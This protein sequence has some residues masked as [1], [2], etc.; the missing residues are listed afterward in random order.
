MEM[1][2]EEKRMRGPRSGRMFYQASSWLP[3]HWLLLVNTL[4]GALVGVAV[5]VPVL[6]AMGATAV[7]RRAPPRLALPSPA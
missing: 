6:Y 1:R 3:A 5:L 2:I 4:L 7:A